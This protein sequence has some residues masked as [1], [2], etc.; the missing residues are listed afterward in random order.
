MAHPP[1][2]RLNPKWQIGPFMIVTEKV[3]IVLRHDRIAL[4][5]LHVDAQRVGQLQHIR[6]QILRQRM[7]RDRRAVRRMHQHG[8]AILD[9]RPLDFQLGPNLPARQEPPAG[10]WSQIRR[11]RCRTD[12]CR[13]LGLMTSFSHVSVKSMSK[14]TNESC[15]P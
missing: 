3:A 15:R 10:A 7:D 12:G 1:E 11:R 13:F 4:K 8:A 9:R 5:N 6:H 2:F 14:A